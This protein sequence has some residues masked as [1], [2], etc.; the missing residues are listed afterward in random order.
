MLS[1]AS[2]QPISIFVC[3]PTEDTNLDV[4]TRKFVFRT[5]KSPH[6]E[7][8]D[9]FYPPKSGSSVTSFSFADF[10]RT[11]ESSATYAHFLL[12]RSS[13]KIS[14]QSIKLLQQAHMANSVH[15]STPRIVDTQELSLPAL[16][17]GAWRRK[18]SSSSGEVDRIPI[19]CKPFNYGRCEAIFF[20]RKDISLI[21]DQVTFNT[22]RSGKCYVRK[23][24]SCQ[25]QSVVDSVIFI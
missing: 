7:L 10:I 13:F 19:E 21:M 8:T 2:D 24:G 17:L 20:V 6:V 12:I 25:V 15:L 5:T 23:A 4:S 14:M 11:A 22:S 3:Q 16:D 9:L 18:R 1:F